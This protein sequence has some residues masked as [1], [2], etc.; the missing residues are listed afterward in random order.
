MIMKPFAL[1]FATVL[2]F[3]ACTYLPFTALTSTTTI[4]A[5]DA[6]ILGN[7]EHGKY[8]VR[9]K[10]ISNSEITVWRV[11]I[12]GGQHTPLQVRANQKSEVKVDRNTALRIENPSL[13]EVSVELR[14]TG[15]TDL[16]MGYKN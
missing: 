11:P 16:S 6:F 1:F 4:K 10:N 12:S 8:S 9:L 13:L 7:N 5:N 3:S 2:V 15:D 14:V